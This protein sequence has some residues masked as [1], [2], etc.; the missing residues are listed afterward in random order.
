[1]MTPE[2]IESLCV[3]IRKKKLQIEDSLM[4]TVGEEFRQY[5]AT[6]T[7]PPS[8]LPPGEMVDRLWSFGWLLY[9]VSFELLQRIRPAYES[10]EEKAAA[11]SFHAAQQIDVL[12]QIARDLPWPEFAPRALGAIRAQALAQ[13]KRDTEPGYDQAW[14]YHEEANK[15]HG[16]YRETQTGEERYEIA[17]DETM[18]QLALAQTGTSCRT[19]EQMIGRWSEG[20]SAGDWTDQE[21]PRITQGLFDRLWRGVA[22]GE[23][24]LAAAADI[25]RRYGLVHAVTSERLA[26]VTS[27]RNPAI[28][29]AR[30]ALLLLPLCIGMEALGR[31]P[32]GEHDSWESM[33]K[34]LLERIEK[35]YADIERPVA[36]A[37]GKPIDL[38]KDHARSLVQIRLNLGL[39]A[40][41]RR[42]PA[43]VT[44]HPCL[45]LDPIDDEAI[46]ALSAWLAEKEGDERRGDA[47]VIG[48][49]T[50]PRFIEQVDAVRARYGVSSGYREWRARWFELDRYVD[51]PGRRERVAEALGVPV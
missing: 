45:E 38:I 46:A 27:Y 6:L 16:H 35:A 43:K 21:Q 20:R 34:D 32:P 11:P 42:L 28:M 22:Y 51:E 4:E 37:D 8:A 50:M 39:V 30:A 25:D 41:G 49:A 31:R 36:A 13:S 26:L 18:I 29:T 5:C 2:E 33:R 15:L 23:Q 40:P 47:N 3:G 24:A 44:F 1:M 19:A 7:D 9:E 17:L 14:A 10:L 48:S 12:A